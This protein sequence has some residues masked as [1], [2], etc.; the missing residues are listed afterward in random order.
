MAIRE[1]RSGEVERNL[2]PVVERLVKKWTAAKKVVVFDHG[3]RRRDPGIDM[4]GGKN[5]YARGQPAT[6]VC[7]AGWYGW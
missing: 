1:K 5:A 6:V 7:R 3:Y 4:A 2:Y